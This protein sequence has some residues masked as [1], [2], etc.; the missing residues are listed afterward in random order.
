[1][2]QTNV[3]SITKC[4]K[5]EVHIEH[6]PQHAQ[7]EDHT[8]LHATNQKRKINN[9]YLKKLF[10]K[11]HLDTGPPRL[12]LIWSLS[13]VVDEK[14]QERNRNLQREMCLKHK[15]SLPHTSKILSHVLTG[16]HEYRAEPQY[17][18]QKSK[19]TVSQN[20]SLNNQKREKSFL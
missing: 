7:K 13:F 19:L 20:K 14:D 6:K 1:M 5:N 16:S 10:Y 12:Q 8:I 3:L 4:K 17:R 18:F 2:H 15:P 11:S 9:Y